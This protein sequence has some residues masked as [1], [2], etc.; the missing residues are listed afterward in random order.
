ME[1]QTLE[2]VKM[3]ARIEGS[4]QEVILMSDQTIQQLIDDI[5]GEIPVLFRVCESIALLDMIASLAHLATTNEQQTE[6][7][8]PQITDCIAISAGRH[9]IRERVG[10][11]RQFCIHGLADH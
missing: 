5:R 3:N 2:L 6:Y 9:P 11:H 10:C 4:H 7:T 8:R 1:C